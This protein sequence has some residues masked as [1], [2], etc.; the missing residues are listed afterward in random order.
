MA[1][2]VPFIHAYVAV[3]ARN[4]SEIADV[5]YLLDFVNL[6]K[7]ERLVSRGNFRFYKSASSLDL[8]DR[9]RNTGV[10]I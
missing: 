3:R 5:E 9:N 2:L 10:S 1:L 4:Y 6:L 8:I 7:S